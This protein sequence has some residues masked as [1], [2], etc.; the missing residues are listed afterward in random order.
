MG[1]TRRDKIDKLTVMMGSKQEIM[2][3]RGNSNLRFI[4][5]EGGDKVEFFMTHIIITEKLSK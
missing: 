2:G 5:A 3:L 4:R 1:L